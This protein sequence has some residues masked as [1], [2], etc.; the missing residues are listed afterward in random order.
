MIYCWY[1][2]KY[3]QK[4]IIIL[5]SR[6]VAQVRSIARKG[7]HGAQVIRRA[8]ILLHSHEG[9]KDAD[10]ARLVDVT[11][12]T[13]ENV[14]RRFA[15]SGIDRA[16]TDAPRTGQPRKIDDTDEAHL[17]AIACSDAPEGRTHWTLVLLQ[18]RLRRDRKKWVSTV[19]IWQRLDARG[20]KPWR[21]KN[22]VH[23]TGG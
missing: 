14:R 8:R 5:S 23:T 2:N 13:V 22:V 6:E 20:I 1:M 7:K 9:M 3:Q 4:H 17:V 16:L 21:E 15:D 11:I 19:A 18:E 10:I 12:R